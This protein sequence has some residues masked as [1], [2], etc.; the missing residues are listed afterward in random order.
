MAHDAGQRI[1]RVG[2]DRAALEAGRLEAVVAAHRQV[3][4]AACGIPAAFDLADAPPVDRRGIA[5]LLVAGDDAALAAD[6]LPHVE[7][8]AVLLAGSGAR[9]GMRA[10]R[11]SEPCARRAG[12]TGRALR[13]RERRRRLPSRASA[14]ADH[15]HSS[16]RHDA[17]VVMT[18]AST[19]SASCATM[20]RR[21]A[22]RDVSARMNTRSHVERARRLQTGPARLADATRAAGRDRRS[23]IHVEREPTRGVD[24]TQCCSHQR[25]RHLCLI[26][27]GRRNALTRRMSTLIHRRCC[28]ASGATASARSDRSDAAACVIATKRTST[29]QLSEQQIR[30]HSLSGGR[31][32]RRHDRRSRQS[33]AL[34]STRPSRRRT[35]LAATER[36]LL[37]AR[38]T[39]RSPRQDRPRRLPCDS[40]ISRT[41]S[42]SCDLVATSSDRCRTPW[43]GTALLVI[44]ARRT[45]SHRWPVPPTAS[46]TAGDAQRRRRVT[47]PRSATPAPPRLPSSEPRQ[48]AAAVV[49]ARARR[50]PRADGRVRRTSPSSTDATMSTGSAAFGSTRPSRHRSTL[51][52]QVQAA[53]RPRGG[54]G[55]GA[56]HRA[57]PGDH[58]IC[59][60]AFADVGRAKAT[61]A[62]RARTP[63]AGVRRAAARRL[64][65][66]WAN[67]ARTLGRARK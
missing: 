15:R 8:E 37:T 11:A 16:V 31:D 64:T 61:V 36:D 48:R 60:L 39:A 12:D 20:A 67:A 45:A 40:T 50:V 22:L 30:R 14:A 23:K 33:R 47:Q 65:A 56:D 27:A 34:R 1:L 3:D 43:R 58:S 32:R 38:A 51:S 17:A 9:S 55:G 10:C 25:I 29:T 21:G 49:A 19:A 54:Q 26:D 66:S 6:A 42:R 4:S 59:A 24:A 41:G 5:V 18:S 28:G 63:G 44:A 53:G 7:V 52:F 57:L 13:Q 35:R 46:R 2:I 62:V